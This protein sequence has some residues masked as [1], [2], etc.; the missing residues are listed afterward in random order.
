VVRVLAEPCSESGCPWVHSDGG[1]RTPAPHSR[2]DEEGARDSSD[3]PERMERHCG[4]RYSRAHAGAHSSTSLGAG[5]APF[6]SN[7]ALPQDESD[8]MTLECTEVKAARLSELQDLEPQCSQSATTSKG[9]ASL[10][11]ALSRDCSAVNGC[12]GDGST[13]RRCTSYRDRSIQIAPL[14]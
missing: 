10:S 7:H 11:K 1:G 3:S 13:S 6:G 14:H 8:W 2:E 9:S 12:P 5:P 4:C